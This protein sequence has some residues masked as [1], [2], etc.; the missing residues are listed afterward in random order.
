MRVCIFIGSYDFREDILFQKI[1]ESQNIEVIECREKINSVGSFVKGYFKMFFR[2]RKLKYDVMLI[3][4]RGI[5]SFPLAKLVCRKPIVYWSNLSIYHTLIDDRKKASPK[6]LYAKLIHFAEKYVCNHCDMI[7]TESKAQAEFLVNEYKLDKGKFRNSVNSVNEEI[8]SPIP[9]KKHGDIFK[10]LFF[11]GFVPAH[12]IET[13]VESAKILSNQEDIIFNFCG[14][15]P[16][17]KQI[18]K[19]VKDNKLTN[20][21]FFGFLSYDKL[22]PII[23]E[24]DVCMGIFGTSEKATNV[25]PNKILQI[26]ASQKPLI[27]MD[28]KGVKEIHLKNEENCIL[29]PS[30]NAEK[31]ANSILFLKGDNEK[32]KNISLNGYKLYSELLSNKV[33]G[34]K[35]EGYFKEV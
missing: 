27:T 4:W 20:V 15:G 23:E 24:S 26:L 2:H 10:V 21:K 18:E 14:D 33:V 16:M 28:S 17:K 25:I 8:F 19:T 5:I 34:K 29:I 22:L 3:P 30:G 1:L 7:I 32:C 9:F 6:S 11:G 13:I 31:L 12:G 35:L